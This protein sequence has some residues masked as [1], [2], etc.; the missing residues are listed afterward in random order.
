MA[1]PAR[2]P[3]PFVLHCCELLGTLGPCRARRMFG[4]WGLSVDG[5]PL[6]LILGDTLYLKVTP[7]EEQ[8]WLEAGCT[9][10]LYE[11]RGRLVNLN[12]YTAPDSA[13]ESPAEM[14]PWARRALASAIKARAGAGAS[15]KAASPGAR[16]RRTRA[17]PATPSS[18]RP[19]A[20]SAKPKARRKSSSG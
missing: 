17:S 15:G 7:G 10:F 2:P 3:D 14:A 11:A 20:P 5:L 4:G 8:P 1:S 6:G 9:P 12:Y 18:S 16:A 19:A 13:M